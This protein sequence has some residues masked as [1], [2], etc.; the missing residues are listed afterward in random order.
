MEPKNVLREM[1]VRRGLSTRGASAEAGRSIGYFSRMI[2][3]DV[4]PKIST[5][6]ELGDAL[7][8]DLILRD[9]LDGHEFVIDPPRGE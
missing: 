4:I 9:R 8:Y 7:D 5:L 3:K 2:S 1:I 6:A